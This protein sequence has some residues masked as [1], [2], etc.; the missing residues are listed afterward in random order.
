[1]SQNEDVQCGLA[2]FVCDG[3]ALIKFHG[4]LV[5]EN[6]PECREKILGLDLGSAADLYL[7]LVDL[8]WLDS[9]GMGI[10]VALHIEGSSKEQR[11]HLMEPAEMVL[12]MLRSANLDKM[13]SIMDDDDAEQ[14]RSGLAKPENTLQV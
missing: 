4:R 1:M 3:R 13:M 11:I 6:V 8:E 5:Q 14:V 12:L 10:L 9:V 2:A 7:D